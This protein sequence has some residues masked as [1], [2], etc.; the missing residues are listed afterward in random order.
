M[1]QGAWLT[2]APTKVFNAMRL[3]S[4]LVTPKKCGFKFS[5]KPILFY[6]HY[7]FP[8]ILNCWGSGICFNSHT[9]LCRLKTTKIYKN[10]VNYSAVSTGSPMP[11]TR[12]FTPEWKMWATAHTPKGKNEQPC[13]QLLQNTNYRNFDCSLIQCNCTCAYT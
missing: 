1:I 12:S 9:G 7:N 8:K 4:T 10:M 3:E 2:S 6:F 5:Y 11:N 13:S